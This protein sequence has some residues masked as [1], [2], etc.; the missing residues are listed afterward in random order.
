MLIFPYSTALTLGRPPYISYA[1]VALCVAVYSLQLG[2]SVTEALMYYPDSWNP[3]TMVSASFAHAGFWHLFGNLVFFMA[4]APALEILLDNWL[5]YLGV[6]LFVALVTGLSYSLWTVLSAAEGV[7]TLGFSGVV[8][9]MIGLAAYLMPHARVRVFCWFFVWKTFF[10]PAWVLAV[11][12][13][14]LDAWAMLTLRDFGG[15]N[16]VAHV[17]GGLAGY[18]YGMLWLGGHKQEISAELADEIEAMRIQQRHGKIPAEAHRY[19]KVIDPLLAEKEQLRD[20]D[21]FMSRIYQM[22]KTHRDSE[23]MLQL[24]TRYD[25][26]SPVT[27]IESLFER[28]FEWGPSRSL[29]CLGRLLIQ[30][31]DG[32][33]RHGRALIYIERCQSLSPK[34]ILPDIS[35]TLF[36][37]QMA[38]D[39]GKPAIAKNL[40][41]NSAQ[42][43]GALVNNQQFNHLLQLAMK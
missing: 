42:R 5:R 6:M 15:V 18:A 39:T 9:G 43:Y 41:E 28:A 16:L 1:A 13:I 32:E 4:F 40:V 10:V 35:R 31:L 30:I 11:V 21:K 22:V 8:M 27:E 38:L 37:A 7:P 12:Y 33:H 19:K 25:L 26:Q 23:A 17:A 14:G 20:H 34:F 36:Y 29:A 24:L 2:T 3:L